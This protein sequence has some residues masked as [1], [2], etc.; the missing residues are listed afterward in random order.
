MFR[1]LHSRL[2]L[3]YA[4]VIVTALAIVGCVL[5]LFL[6]RN[7]LI[8][9]ST[10]LRLAEAQALANARAGAADATLQLARA[11]NVRVLLFGGDGSLLQDTGINQPAL[12]L[13]GDPLKLRPSGMERDL[14]GKPWLYALSQLP[15]G[16]WLVIAAP[17]PKVA[18]FLAVLT[19][20]LS[21]PFMEGGV[22]AL[23][24]SLV[25]AFVI[26]RWVAVPLERIV[27]AARTASPEDIQP[28]DVRG[29]REVQELARAFNAMVSRVR[30]SRAAQR[31]FV[32]NVSH[33]LK[34]PLT[35]I[36]G[37]A[38]ALMDGT[39]DTPAA[40]KQAAEV[41]FNEAGR[42]HRMALDLL[43]LA[44]LD[45]GTAQFTQAPVDIPALINSIC[46]KFQ[47]MALGAGITLQ[48]SVPGRLP[49]L[50][51]DGDRLAQVFGNLVDNALKFTPRGGNVEIRARQEQNEIQ[52][53]VEDTGK[54]IPAAALPHIFDRFYRADRARA[55]GDE[56]GAGLGL[57][58]AHEIVAAHGGRITVRSAEGRGTGFVVHLPITN[59]R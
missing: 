2:W 9:R 19:D 18:P 4:V 46:D 47:P 42:M 31:D 17:R 23:L 34:T 48:L 13:P 11:F 28:V 58:I 21:T 37:F 51:G 1:S 24:L 8:Y 3:S 53:V 29:P 16:R 40:R 27:S 35:S 55:G 57:A 10:Y 20:E 59:V 52:I 15:D 32:A 41:I 14:S 50:M 30:V 54:G 33:E 36:Q 7:P 39:A 6:A 22:I 45:S 44:R 26:A 12:A 25:L 38:Q 49:A 56:H 43:D 5:I